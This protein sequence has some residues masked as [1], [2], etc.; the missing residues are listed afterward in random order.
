[1][2]RSSYSP[3]LLILPPSLFYPALCLL[4]T[5]APLIL[6]L[7]RH[8]RETLLHKSCRI[9]VLSS[10]HVFSRDPAPQAMPLKTLDPD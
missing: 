3:T 7:L 8:P 2:Y 1:M 5:L 4:V 6:A 10:R 9:R